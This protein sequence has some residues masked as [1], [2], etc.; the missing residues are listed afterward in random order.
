LALKDRACFSFP[1]L[2]HVLRG[3][4][5]RP[6]QGLLTDQQRRWCGVGELR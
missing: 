6:L 1:V 4:I 2:H 5:K 3:V